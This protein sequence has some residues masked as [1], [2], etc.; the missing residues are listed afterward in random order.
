MMIQHEHH[1]PPPT[2]VE[3]SAPV[4]PT[5]HA[6]ERLYSPRA[7]AAARAQLMKEHGGMTVWTVRAD[8]LEY[9]SPRRRRRPG[10]RGRGLVG[11]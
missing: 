11:S 3:Q 4:A 9:R 8:Q 7:M 10:L 5:D 1:Q 2:A 6:A